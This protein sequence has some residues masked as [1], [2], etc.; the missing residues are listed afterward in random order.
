MAKDRTLDRHARPAR[1]WRPD[2]PELWDQLGEAAA[3]AGKS[4][5][6]V[7]NDLVQQHLAGR[8]APDRRAEG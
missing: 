1:I 4:R 8:P 2:P 7:L 6:E 3:A 5:S